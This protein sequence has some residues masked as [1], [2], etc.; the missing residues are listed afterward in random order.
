MSRV[1]RAI[2]AGRCAL[3]V[4]GSLL[5]D[6]EVMLAL[7]ERASLTPMALAGPAVSPVLPVTPEG[8]ARAVAQPGGVVVVVEPEGADANGIQQLGDLLKRGKHK[9]EVVIVARNFNPFAFPALAG[10]K[11]NHEKGRGKSF[12]KTLPEP[13][14]DASLANLDAAVASVKQGKSKKTSNA[15]VMAFVGREHEL[16]NMQGFLGEGGPIVVSG[17]QGVGKTWLVE[18]ALAASDL[19]RAPDV[20]LGFDTGHDALVGRIATVAEEGGHTALMEHL[21]GEHTP[22]SLADAVMAAVKDE[23]LAD[24]VLVVRH[25]D[26]AMGRELDFF[27]KSRLELLALRLLTESYAMRIVFTSVRQPRFLREGQGQAVRRQPVAGVM[28]RFLNEIFTSY[29]ALELPRDKFGPISDRIHGHVMAART[30]AICTR[31]RQDG[32]KIAD[33]PKFMKME[34]LGHLDPVVKQIRKRLE[35]VDPKVREALAIL[36]HI[37]SDADGTFL[38]DLKI[39]RA[40]RL[41]LLALG[42]LD[43][44]GTL[45]QRR[46]HVHPLVRRQ[47]A[48]R[49]I[50]DFA[51]YRK[52]HELYMARA[53]KSSGA[54]K[55]AFLQEAHRCATNARAFR[56]RP[57]LGFP[58]HDA[59]LDSV[60]AMRKGKE[61][62]FDLM[63][64]RIA[65]VLKMDPSNSDGWILRLEVMHQQGAKNEDL[66][67][68]YEEAVKV[69]PVPELFQAMAG[70]LTARRSRNQAITVLEQGIELCPEDQSSRLRTRLASMLL[71]VGRRP[72]A[73]EQLRTAMNV[74]PMLP[75]AYGLL[76]QAR[77][78]EG[79]DKIGEAEELL[80]EAVRLAPE[81]TVQT[82]RLASLLMVRARIEPD[83]AKALRDEAK[84]MLTE[85]LR[86]EQRAPEAHLMLA[87]LVRESGVDLERADWLLKQAKKHTDR[88]H[89]RNN[90]LRLESA[91]VDMARG[92]LDHA[93]QAVRK[94]IGKD[95]S[96]GAAF[97]GLGHILEAKEQFIPAHAEYQRAKERSAAGSP[98]AVYFDQQIARVQVVIEAQAAGLWQGTTDEPEALPS[99]HSSHAGEVVRRNKDGEAAAVEAAPAEAAPVE[100]PA[101]PAEASPD[102]DALLGGAPAPVEVEAPAPVKAEAPA[103]VE[104]EAPAPVEAAAEAVTGQAALADDVAEQ[105]APVEVTSAEEAPVVVDAAPVAE[106]VESTEP[107]PGG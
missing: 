8:I 5:R 51:T 1:E 95:P 3:A 69:A 107:T 28:G 102:V 54:L 16:A 60:I 67:A 106:A 100:A 72:E 83:N 70:L 14:A 62:R 42:L 91:L 30:F 13:P 68:V 52:L 23:A 46:Y 79:L 44:T 78:D 19:V 75:D 4:S 84:E 90:R 7:S 26:F 58:N 18:H 29:K 103:P 50:H 17:P 73:I 45:E 6:P 82:S 35:K 88:H 43:M 97:V 104:V 89:E 37:R 85:A 93:E 40:E 15:P 56:E 55:T 2:E 80:R 22:N 32:E 98:D 49:E 71:R 41:E 20:V 66:Q 61:P 38:A 94:I 99:G 96:L 33:D 47:L 64:Q 81:D 57:D 11:I 53:G 24:R 77:R 27:R 34:S 9:P 63:E 65:E 87:T 74:D 25:L 31:V 21:K 101:A 92:K 86:G 59:M 105:A 12:L 10:M 48:W 76:G 39:T 36:A